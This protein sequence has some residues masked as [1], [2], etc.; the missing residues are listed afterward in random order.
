MTA[1]ARVGS[2]HHVAAGPP[3]RGDDAVDRRRREVRTVGEHDDRRFRFGGERLETA[4][5]RRARPALPL[6]AVH[7]LRRRVERVRP[8]YHQ[9]TLDRAGANSLEDGLDQEALFGRAEASRAAGSQ[10]D[11]RNRH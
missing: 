7:G 10:N 3:P 11:R 5:K 9:H 4:A 8:D 6:R 1:L 2:G